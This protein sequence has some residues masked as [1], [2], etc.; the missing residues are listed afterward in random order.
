MAQPLVRTVTVSTASVAPVL[1]DALR[2]PTCASPVRLEATELVCTAEDHRYPIVDGVVVAIRDEELDAH[3]QYEHQRAYFD[4]EFATARD[5]RDEPWRLSYLRRLGAG[6]VLGAEG[7]TLID[8][9]VGGTGYTVI[10][11]ARRGMSAVGCD[12]SLAGLVS[13]RRLAESAGVADRTLWV[14]CSAEKLPFASGAFDSAVAVAVFEHVPDDR[15][16]LQETARV[17]KPGGRAWVTVPHALRYINRIFRPSNRRHDRKLGHL[18][19][20]EAEELV[21]AGKDAG[22]EAEDVQFTGHAVK[23]AQL[24]ADKA[25]G[26]RAARLWWWCER[27]DL[28]R[29]GV[30]AGSMQLS[31]LFSRPG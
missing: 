14:C 24:A 3:A 25:L 23:V 31:V 22:L 29:A 15:A 17:L 18:R 20:Y 2:C 12:L 8:V 21:A 26:R 11:A 19:R 28:R 6:G 5:Y 9:G 13:A 30:P 4:A 10:E 27:R 1:A 7:S 16:A